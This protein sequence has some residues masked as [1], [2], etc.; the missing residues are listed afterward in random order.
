VRKPYRLALAHLWAAGIAWDDDLLPV[1]ACPPEE[2][3]VLLR[4]LERGLNT[5]PTSSAGRLFDAV[6]SLLGIR[7]VVE[8]EGQAAIELEACAVDVPCTPYEF[9]VDADEWPILIDPEPL[10]RALCE[11]FCQGIDRARMSGWFHLALAQALADTA[12]AVR[13]KTGINRVA[14]SGG[15]FANQR[16]LHALTSSLSDCCFEVYAHRQVPASDAGLAL[17]QAAVAHF[18]AWS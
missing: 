1:R 14:L 6:A 15:V 8:F 10:L 17:G 7:Q 9:C 2:G 3:R 16:L 18:S 12:L 5:V 4:Q 11:D 13:A